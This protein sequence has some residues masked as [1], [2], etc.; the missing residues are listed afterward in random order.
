MPQH[1]P[2]Q[3]GRNRV[4]RTLDRI[5]NNPVASIIVLLAIGIGALASLTDSVARLRAALPSFSNDSVVGEWKSDLVDIYNAG[6]EY[7]RLH[8]REVNGE[9]LG[10]VQFSG[11][12]RLLPRRFDVIDGKHEGATVTLA[13][14]SGAWG[15]GA[16]GK[17]TPLRETLSGEVSDDALHLVHHLQN[18]G[19]VSLVA[20]RAA[21]ADQL[22]DGRWAIRY[23]RK[24]YADHQ[25]ACTQLLS[26]LE[27]PQIYKQSEPPD[28]EGHVHCVGELADG[29]DGFDMYM[30]EIRREIICPSDS[31]LTLVEGGSRESPRQCECDG[32]RVAVDGRCVDAQ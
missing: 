3:D 9:V 23:Q 32:E 15:V 4:D 11:N 8:L 31:R 19:A 30:N 25:A 16:D 24:E 28:A 18:R 2:Q 22:I 13:F 14:D 26:E 10:F 21:Q 12:E 5:K 17:S 29:S 7:L 27:P 6:P 1:Q 20:H